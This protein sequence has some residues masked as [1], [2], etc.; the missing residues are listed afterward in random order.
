MTAVQVKGLGRR[1]V[2]PWL[3]DPAEPVCPGLYQRRF[4]NGR[5]AWARWSGKW[6]AATSRPESAAEHRLVA[7][8]A[9]IENSTW[10]GLTKPWK[11]G[12]R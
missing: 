9:E 7:S 5:V 2:T 1:E 11:R 10:R 12:A 4:S 6:Y 3:S 8:V